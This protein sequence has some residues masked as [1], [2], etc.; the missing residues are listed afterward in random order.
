MR[1]LLVSAGE[2]GC[3]QVRRRHGAVGVLVVLVDA[4]PVKAELLGVDQLVDVPVVVRASGSRVEKRVRT[5]DPCRP[6]VVVRQVR[7][8]H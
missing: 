2:D 1:T 5:G 7:V 8:G 4:D 6:V 3:D